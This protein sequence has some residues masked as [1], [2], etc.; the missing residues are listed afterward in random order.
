MK[1]VLILSTA[2]GEGHNQ[3]AKS[4]QIT[5]ER[6]GF[7]VYIEDFLQNNSK[8]LSTAFIGG[9]D[10]FAVKFPKLYGVAYK[11]TDNYLSILGL[12][13][14]YIFTK[15]KI[16]KLIGELKPDFIISTHP[17]AIPLLGSLKR[18]GLNIPVMSIVTDFKAH[19]SYIDKNIDYY[20]TGSNYTKNELIKD[21]IDKN[22][23]YTY[24]IPIK[25]EF[26][27][28]FPELL[29]TKDDDYFN[30]LL[31]GGS[32]GLDNIKYVLKELLNNSHNLRITVICGNNVKLKDSLTNEYKSKI[33][34]KKL[35][36]LGFCNDIPSIMEYS[37]LLISKPGGLTVT[38]AFVKNLPLIIPFSIPGQETY[39]TDFL[40]KNGYAIGIDSLLELNLVVD[41]LIDN[42]TEF[43]NLKNNIKKIASLYSKQEIVN[44]I[45]NEI[46]RVD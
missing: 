17:F 7:E 8:I 10:F 41:N 9:Y 39:N 3:A 23:I 37:D 43:N 15:N 24:G 14:A 35:H 5:L 16:K 44:L 26:Y 25:D 46:N 27:F 28:S 34:G 21:G 4:L 22:K 42:K 2:T 45:S 29:T 30:I 1:K 19:F 31:M 33:R 13:I 38:E 32:M 40:K 6:N 18:K 20:I 36:I 11:L 12:N